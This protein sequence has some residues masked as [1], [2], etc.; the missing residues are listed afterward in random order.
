[1]VTPPPACTGPSRQRDGCTSPGPQR[2]Q[3]VRHTGAEH[4]ALHT[5]MQARRKAN[6]ALAKGTMQSQELK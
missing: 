5:R 3:D 4:L 6:C 2:Q 1:M